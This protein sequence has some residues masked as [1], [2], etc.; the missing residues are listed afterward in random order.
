LARPRALRGWH[1][2]VF[3]VVY[4]YA[5]P[6]FDRLRNANEM[7]RIVMTKAMVDQRVFY[8][9]KLMGELRSRNDTS[10]APDGHVYPNKP[11]GPSL[12]AVPVYVVCKL[13]GATSLRAVTWAFR[14]TVVT[15]PS[16]LFL[17]VFYRL[18]RRFGTDEPSRRVALLAYA[19]GSQAMPYALLFMSHALTAV[20]CGA[21]FASAVRLVRKASGPPGWAALWVG[22]ASALGVAMDYQAVLPGIVIGLYVVIFAPRRLTGLVFMVLGALPIALFSAYYHHLA[23]GGVFKTG[24]SYAV[25]T[26]VKHGFMGLVGPSWTSFVNTMLLPSNGLLVLAPWVVLAI[27]GAVMVAANRRLRRRCGPEALACLVILLGDILMLSS[28]VPYMSRSGWGVGPRYMTL[29]MPFV[30]W[31]ALVGLEGARRNRATHILAL[32]L[33]AA[34]IAVFVVG[35]TT[36]PHWPD[37]LKNPLYDL[38]F[39]LLQRGYAVHS[40][41]TAVGLS[42]FLAILPLYIF[43]AGVALWLLGLGRRSWGRAVL[44]CG[45]ATLL[46]L[47]HRA[48]PTTDQTR[49]NPWPMICSIWEPRR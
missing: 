17:P 10:I 8:I 38:V 47:A 45:M 13:L 22:V 18:G 31:L 5:F 15:I 36:F 24:Y 40:L 27:A 41:G 46:V 39:P 48:F 32:A 21:A 30:A 44:V 43:V 6:Y 1:F 12:L 25:D 37:R 19:L 14:A 26:A 7:P 35:G 11:P 3:A 20:F 34:S 9:D 29:A 33:V 28:L 16:V 2:L 4:L 42:G 49:V 23:Y